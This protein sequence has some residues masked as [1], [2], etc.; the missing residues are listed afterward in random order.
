MF[1]IF[2][3]Q[4][5]DEQAEG[6]QVPAADGQGADGDQDGAA[7][8]GFSSGD[9]QSKFQ[10]VGSRSVIS[11]ICHVQLLVSVLLSVLSGS[12]IKVVS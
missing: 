9:F 12:V 2:G 1:H 7:A 6:V 8:D 11:V 10:Q 3:D 4:D 5:R